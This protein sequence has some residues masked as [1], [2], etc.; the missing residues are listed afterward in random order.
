MS[1]SDEPGVGGIHSTHCP[2]VKG[3]GDAVTSR[4]QLVTRVEA[5]NE[6]DGVPRQNGAVFEPGIDMRLVA[7]FRNGRSKQTVEGE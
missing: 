3:Q 2:L 7:P 5:T 1:C 4:G 6:V